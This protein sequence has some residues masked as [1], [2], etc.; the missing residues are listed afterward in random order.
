MKNT[1][2]T[3]PTVIGQ[4]R[5]LIALLASALEIEAQ[6]L[7]GVPTEDQGASSEVIQ[8]EIALDVIEHD[9]VNALHKAD[10]IVG[11]LGRIAERLGK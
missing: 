11:Q 1:G 6:I 4:V 2:E 5:K 10:S 9:L 8:D 3:K 7:G